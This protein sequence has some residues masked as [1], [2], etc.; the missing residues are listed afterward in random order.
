MH[1]LFLLCT[2]LSMV[3]C[4][5]SDCIAAEEMNTSEAMK[6]RVA[7]SDAPISNSNWVLKEYRKHV[8]I[9]A[10]STWSGWPCEKLI[11]D[12]LETSWFSAGRDSF[13]Q[14]T[15]PWIEISLNRGEKVKRITLLGNR[16]PRWR[17]GY[18]V[19]IGK[20]EFL[21]KAGKVIAA[22]VEE[23]ANDAGD[24]D[25]VLKDPAAGVFKIRFTS[26]GDEGTENPYGDIA[27]GEIQIE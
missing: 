19:K 15:E 20:F 26:T 25:C 4:V 6:G 3:L 5:P 11:D 24:I 23:A 27:I 21:D 10:S 22:K 9:T 17:Y 18:A 8:V 12:D 7:Y 16:E 13:A 2:L 1:K 14:G